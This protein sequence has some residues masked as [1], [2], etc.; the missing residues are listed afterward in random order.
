MAPISPSIEEMSAD[1]NAR[2]N[3]VHMAPVMAELSRRVAYHLSVNP[4]HTT[5][6]L[7]ELKLSAISTPIGA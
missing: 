3:V 7:D 1:R 4:P 2:I 5:R 6:D